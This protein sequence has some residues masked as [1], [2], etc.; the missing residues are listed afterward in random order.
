MLFMSPKEPKEPKEKSGENQ[1][2]IDKRDNKIY[3]L[4]QFQKDHAEYKG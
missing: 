4:L 3:D 1:S 2:T